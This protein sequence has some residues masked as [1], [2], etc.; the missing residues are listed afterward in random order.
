MLSLL[1]SL[2]EFFYE[3]KFW[4]QQKYAASVPS[5][6][7]SIIMKVAFPGECDTV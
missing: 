2:I 4:K 6:S 1:V 5:I 7:V 3:L